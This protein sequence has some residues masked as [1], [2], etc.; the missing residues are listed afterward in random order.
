M[1]K[2]QMKSTQGSGKGQKNVTNL[3]MINNMSNLA[4]IQEFIMNEAAENMFEMGIDL[5][6]NL[7]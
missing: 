3:G 5:K 2:E 1:I 7:V 6:Y 4:N